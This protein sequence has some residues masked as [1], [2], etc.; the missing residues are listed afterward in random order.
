MP[1]LITGQCPTP[2]HLSPELSWTFTPP[3]LLSQED[4][5]Q[6]QQQQQ[7]VEEEE[8]E[9]EEG[10]EGMDEDRMPGTDLAVYGEH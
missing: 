1:T 9:E 6:Q 8:E 7:A 2:R 10:V 3:L 4:E 5:E